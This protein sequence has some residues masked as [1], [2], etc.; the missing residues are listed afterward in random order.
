MEKAGARGR[1]AAVAEP[2]GTGLHRRAA[3]VG[4]GAVQSHRA[5]AVHR[6][7]VATRDRYLQVQ[8]GPGRGLEAVVGPQGQGQA[9][10]G[11]AKDDLRAGVG[12]GQ[13]LV[14]RQG[15]RRAAAAAVGIHLQQGRQ[16]VERSVKGDSTGRA[17]AAKAHLRQQ[18]GSTVAA[19]EKQLGRRRLCRQL[20]AL[21]VGGTVPRRAQAAGTAIPDAGRAGR[22]AEQD[23]AATETTGLPEPRRRAG[24]RGT[25]LHGAPRIPQNIPAI[26]LK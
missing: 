21:P 14:Q 23:E 1:A 4:A 16:A 11:T 19:L 3:A 6:Q 18:R 15:A 26:Y 10:V 9:A 7:A 12:Q 24:E 13:A 8:Q 25:R 20:V 5:G 17:V 2:Q 22:E